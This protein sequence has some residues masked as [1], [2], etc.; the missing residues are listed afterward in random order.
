MSR[1]TFLTQRHIASIRRRD[2]HTIDGMPGDCL[3]VAVVAALGTPYDETPH[4]ALYRRSWWTVMRMHARTRQL[5]WTCIWPSDLAECIIPPSA[6]MLA[7]GPS[8]RGPW[9]HV[10]VTDHTGRMVHDPHPSRAGLESIEEFLVLVD[11]YDP[12]PELRQLTAGPDPVDLEGTPGLCHC[13]GWQQENA[14]GPW[15]GDCGHHISDHNGPGPQIGETGPGV[16]EP[17]S[18]YL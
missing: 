17:E 14:D 13:E 16:C 1:A 5:D 3:R 18:E 2:G 15:C 9:W 6:L 4:F 7:C 11:P 10:V 8:P 12:A